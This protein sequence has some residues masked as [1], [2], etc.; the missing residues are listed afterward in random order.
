MWP[1]FWTSPMTLNG[2]IFKVRFW[3]SQISR[4]RGLID[5][6]WKGYNVEPKMQPWTLTS[7]LT[8]HWISGFSRSNFKIVVFQE[9]MDWLIWNKRDMNRQD[10]GDPVCV[11]LPMTLTLDFQLGLF[12]TQSHGT[13]ACYQSPTLDW[14]QVPGYLWALSFVKPMK[15]FSFQSTASVVC[16]VTTAVFI[17]INPFSVF[18]MADPPSLLLSIPRVISRGH[19][20]V[21]ETGCDV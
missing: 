15:P 19:V 18:L 4:M 11:T 14:K 2:W 3:N 12:T 9:S 16:S 13:R 1:W 7:T 6:E 8:G 17:Y 20:R 10:D 21:W 5:M